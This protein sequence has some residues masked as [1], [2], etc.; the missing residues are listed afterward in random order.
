MKKKPPPKRP[1]AKPGKPRKRVPAV[2]RKRGPQQ[3]FTIQ[4]VGAALIASRGL[5]ADAAKHLGCNRRTVQRMIDRH[6]ELREVA[7]EVDEAQ[8]DMAESKLFDSIEA[9]EPWAI[10]FYLRC[11]AKDRGYVERNELTGKDGKPLKAPP[12]YSKLNEAELRSLTA[13]LEKLEGKDGDG[14]AAAPS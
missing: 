8:K 6:A 5:R 2:A 11:K 13:I 9:R 4:Q 12:D 10:Q 7:A 1:R 14:G 3:A